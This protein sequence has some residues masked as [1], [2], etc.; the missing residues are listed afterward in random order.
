MAVKGHFLARLDTLG[1]GEATVV[2]GYWPIGTEVD[3]RPLLARLGER[4][5]P[6]ALPVLVGEGLPLI[7]R[8]WCPPDPVEDGPRGTRQPSATAPEVTP[9]LLLVPLLGFDGEGYR[10]GQGG[11]YYDRTLAKLRSQRPTIA[12]GIGYSVL[13]REWLPHGPHDQRMDWILTE[14]G[15]ERMPA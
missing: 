15:L 14:D 11:G 2:A 5:V 10:L 12:V 9:D 13:R 6:C 3:D 1:I 8:R 7:F 4:G